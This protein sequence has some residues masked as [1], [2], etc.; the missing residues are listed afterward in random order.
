MADQ[1]LTDAQRAMVETWER[2]TSAEF[3]TKNVDATMATMTAN[4]FVNHVPLMTGGVGRDAVRSFYT[5]YFIPGQPPDT[6][7][8]P[9]RRTV[10]TDCIVDELIYSFTH[11]IEVPWML[12]GV[13]PTG[14]RVEVPVVAVVEFEGGKIAG[15]RIYWDQASALVQIGLLDERRLPVTGAEAARKVVDAGAEQSN[16]LITRMRGTRP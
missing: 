7:L 10:G 5:S 1:E 3:S 4:P 2:H 9:V 13:E 14:R 12:P 16:Q 11:T 6:K 8:V 15:E